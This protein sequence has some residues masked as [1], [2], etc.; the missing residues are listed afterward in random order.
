MLTLRSCKTGNKGVTWRMVT[1]AHPQP[2][3]IPAGS[4][5][6]TDL[7]TVQVHIYILSRKNANHSTATTKTVVTTTTNNNNEVIYLLQ[8]S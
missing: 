6:R 2:E 4:C 1:L 5:S 3:P 7:S 8:I